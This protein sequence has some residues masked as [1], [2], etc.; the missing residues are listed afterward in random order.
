MKHVD[1]SNNQL[2]G[3]IDALLAPSL[4]YL[5]ASHNNFTSLSTFRSYKPSHMTLRTLDLSTNSIQQDLSTILSNVPPNLVHFLLAKNT[6]RGSFPTGLESLESLQQLDISSNMISGSLPDF[7]R[8]YSSL[9]VLNLSDNAGYDDTGLTG[10]VPA[11]I[12]NL[13]FL[14]EVHLSN[15]RLSGGLSGLGG[16]PQIEKL[17][18]SVNKFTG[19]VPPELGSLAGEI[20]AKNI[21]WTRKLIYSHR[22]GTIEVLDLSGNRFEGTIPTEMGL[23]Q[24]ETRISLSNNAFKRASHRCVVPCCP[25]TDMGPLNKHRT[26]FVCFGAIESVFD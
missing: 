9:Q 17:D 20:F 22:L 2:S 15:N 26:Q 18:L 5:N 21:T 25:H 10:D 14:Q 16:M 24:P 7:S 6:I 8:S 12:S 1:I 4:E 11:G 19:N 23:F 3:Q 13:A